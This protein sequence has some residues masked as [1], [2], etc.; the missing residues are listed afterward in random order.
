MDN[1]Q[2][3]Y[4]ILFHHC[5]E[6]SENYLRTIRNRLASGKD[7]QQAAG[8]AG[9]FTQFLPEQLAASVS[10]KPYTSLPWQILANSVAGDSPLQDEAWAFLTKFPPI[11]PLPV[12]SAQLAAFEISI[13]SLI[14]N[15]NK[16]LSQLCTSPAGLYLLDILVD[17]DRHPDWQRESILF[18][19]ISHILSNGYAEILIKRAVLLGFRSI[20]FA[21]DAMSREP[22]VAVDLS[23]FPTLYLITRLIAKRL[24]QR[25]SS[26]DKSN[27]SEADL[28]VV[29]YLSESFKLVISLLYTRYEKLTLIHNDSNQ[30]IDIAHEFQRYYHDSSLA[31]NEV[32]LLLGVLN[33]CIP[34][35]TLV[36]KIP[37]PPG[38]FYDFC[39]AVGGVKRECVHFI[40][41]AAHLYPATQDDVR[42]TDGGLSV[43]LSQ[44]NIDDFNPY[45]REVTVLCIRHLLQNNPDNQAFIAN[46][47]PVGISKSEVLEEAG[48]DSQIDDNGKVKLVPKNRL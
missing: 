2:L 16:R 36:Q 32:L 11:L 24:H 20:Y 44:C 3:D 27:I 39:E 14:L 26:M 23:L 6:D 8:E 31:T 18:R 34:R 45:L 46:L 25:V 30:K 48:Y 22:F 19:I 33:Q 40:T 1:Q 9:L 42:N 5:N 12:T 10:Q 41:F 17:Q 28:T 29:T 38:S 35:K 43:I 37:I 7:V 15:N 13:W 47:N 4:A 21:V